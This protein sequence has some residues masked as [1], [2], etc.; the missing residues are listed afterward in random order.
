[1]NIIKSLLIYYKNLSFYQFILYHICDTSLPSGI[2]PQLLKFPVVKPLYSKDERSC[3]SNYRPVS[4][5][6]SLTNVSDKLMHNRLLG[7]SKDNNILGGEKFGFR[8]NLTNE[9]TNY[10]IINAILIV[11]N[12]KL[13]EGYS[14][15]QHKPSIVLIKFYCQIYFWGEGNNHKGIW[16][17]Q[18]IPWK[19]LF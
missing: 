10:E 9:V 13:W 1:M 4:L 6:T 18:I 17:Y 7:H 3:I 12:V 15:M 8:K 11:L 14:V 16:M 2:F 5:M 19:Y